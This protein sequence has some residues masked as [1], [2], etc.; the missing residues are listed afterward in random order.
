MNPHV[1][2]PLIPF[3]GAGSVQQSVPP[4][5]EGTDGRGG[6]GKGQQWQGWPQ[7]AVGTGVLC[8]TGIACVPQEDGGDLGLCSSLL[9]IKRKKMSGLS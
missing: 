9:F 6:Q 4:L 8:D 3:G 1:V 5:G 7:G 2:G